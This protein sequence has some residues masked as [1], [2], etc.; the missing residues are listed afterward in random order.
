MSI[1]VRVR[2]PDQQAVVELILGLCGNDRGFDSEQELID[3]MSEDSL[4]QRS[5]QSAQELIDWY[6]THKLVPN[7]LVDIA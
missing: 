6:R 7:G 4:L 5:T 1:L 2:R 3:K